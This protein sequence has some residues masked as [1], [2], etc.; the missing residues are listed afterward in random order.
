MEKK[1]ITSLNISLSS[2]SKNGESRRFTISG[3]Y[4]ASFMFQVSN[5][6]GEFYNFN[7][8]LFTAGFTTNSNL[9]KVITS[10]QHTD[11]IVFPSS[12]L[13][14]T[15]NILLLADPS[16]S[17]TVLNGANVISRSI[18]Q[19]ANTTLTL[20]LLTANTSKYSASPPAS[21][22]TSAG[23]PISSKATPVATDWSVIT[24]ASNGHAYGLRL[25]RQ[26]QESDW[27]F[28]NTQTVD[29]AVGSTTQDIVLDSV[30]NLVVGTQ[31]TGVSGGSLSGTPKIIKIRPAEKT[32]ILSSR[33]IFAD[34]I[35]LTFD[36]VGPDL[37]KKATGA[38]INFTQGSAKSKKL[39]KTVR[40]AGSNAVIALNNTKGVSGGSKVTVEGLNYKTAA[41]NTIQSVVEDPDGSGE[42]GT[43]TMQVSQ[44]T[45]M[46]VGTVLNFKGST[47]Q[48]DIS[49]VISIKAYPSSNTTISLLLDNFITPGTIS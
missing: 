40:A 38:S 48:V 21:N 18:T 32:I 26:P 28:R 42:D 29:G 13:G 33:Q 30:A 34:D 36:A 8:K 1:N 45:A 5:G 4:G 23:I 20:A 6:S 19:L 27:V 22:I 41:T 37:I 44:T 43:M 25:T 10:G 17:T 11:T 46:K 2:L 15:Y 49:G 16:T 12:A 47:D 9:N 14:D 7:T 35:T 3:S 31:V 39:T 24:S